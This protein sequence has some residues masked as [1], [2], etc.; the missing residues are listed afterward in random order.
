[1]RRS[2]TLILL[3]LPFALYLSAQ[4]P[5]RLMV[6]GDPHVLDTSLYDNGSAFTSAAAGSPRVL[7]HSAEL[8][9][10]A[11]TIVA[12]RQPA[13]LILVG[14]MANDGE[15]ASHQHIVS[16]LAALQQ[17]GIQ[18]IVIP[19]N[20]DINNRNAK[21]Y[22][23][24]TTSAAAAISTTEYEAM[25]GPFGLNQAVS[26]ETDG[27]SYMVYVNSN[28]ALLCLNS[29]KANTSAVQYHAGGLTEQTLQW[30]EQAASQ[31]RLSGHHVLGMLHHQAL[32][33]F[34]LA[35]DLVPSYIANTESEYPSLA[36]MQD[37]LVAA[38]VNVVLTGHFHIH[39]IKYAETTNGDT[40]YD[41]S[42]ASLSGYPSPIRTLSYTP[43]G[44]LAISTET[45]D[46]YHTLEREQNG[47]TAAGAIGTMANQ[48]Y[49]KIDSV[50]SKLP[51]MVVLMLNLPTSAQQMKSDM[52]TYML[53]PMTELV[54][55]LSAGDEHLDNPEAKL[56]ACMDGFDAYI[57]YICNGNTIA[58]AAVKTL[59][60]A[61][62]LLMRNIFRSVFYNF[63]GSD[64]TQIV[65]DNANTLRLVPL[66]RT[67]L[68]ELSG[69]DAAAQ[70]IWRD[71]VLY[72][73]R[74][75]KLYTLTGMEVL[76]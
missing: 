42:T 73:R 37:R 62:K 10:S 63:V 48:F 39:S 51:A 17:Q 14:D 28:L 69:D 13:V 68:D 76:E 23:G 35:E 49:P 6:V 32:E 56:E 25:Y 40:L 30:A 15:Q 46:T 72:I 70:K 50:K 43:D 16:R 31:A 60:A 9:D 29:A 64:S 24:S 34:N 61:P 45:I 2:F 27:L 65:L 26:R 54:N 22:H 41:V 5:L 71:G 21:R 55:S 3:F 36:S 7:A 4:S 75:G 8:F 67:G 59:V 33:H 19:G 52:C 20:N 47:V 44:Q 58:K 11:M 57:N 74:E 66:E 18:P 53:A 38:G 12:R 1:M